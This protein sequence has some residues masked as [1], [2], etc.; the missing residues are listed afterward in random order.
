MVPLSNNVC[1]FDQL[2]SQALASVHAGLQNNQGIPISD[3]AKWLAL[4]VPFFGLIRI[5][6]CTLWGKEELFH[7]ILCLCFDD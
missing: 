6:F 2:R 7:F 5:P 1:R 3:I 4:E